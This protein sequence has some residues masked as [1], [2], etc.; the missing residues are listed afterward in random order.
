MNDFPDDSVKSKKGIRLES[1][2]LK[3]L[4]AWIIACAAWYLFTRSILHRP[5]A[6]PSL[7]VAPEE[8]DKPL[9]AVSEIILKLRKRSSGLRLWAT[10]ILIM[11]FLSLFSCLALFLFAGSI[12]RQENS[13]WGVAAKQAEVGRVLAAGLRDAQV[14]AHLSQKSSEDLFR[15]YIDR[16]SK[17][18]KRQDDPTQ[19]L[20]STIVTRIGSVFILLFLVQI[21]ITFYRYNVRLA[22]YYD[23][24]A[25]ALQ[26]VGAAKEATLQNLVST[27]SPDVMDFGKMPSTP[28][29]QALEL[30]K[31]VVKLSKQK[32]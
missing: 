8:L 9:E 22:N 15:Y 24:R 13:E 27:L 23:A 3:V 18:E 19:F 26:L 29:E 28:T 14:I 10:M 20:I 2:F 11:M 1:R 7:A 31:E 4:Q 21:L 32:D 17:Y 25:D 16:I 30:A 12:S 6:G 5:Q